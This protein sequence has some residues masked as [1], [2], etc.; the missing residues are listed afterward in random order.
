MPIYRVLDIFAAVTADINNR[1]FCNN[2]KNNSSSDN[3]IWILGGFFG[4]ISPVLR[5]MSVR[6]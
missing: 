1:A 4:R 2:N 6:S 5:L 3:N